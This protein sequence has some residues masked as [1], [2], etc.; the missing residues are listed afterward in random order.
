M[1]KA[2]PFTVTVKVESATQ[3]QTEIDAA[4]H[5]AWLEGLNHA[6]TWLGL[7]HYGDAMAKDNP[8]GGGK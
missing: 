7:K 8:H 6:L 4:K 2:G 3:R 5:A 1:A